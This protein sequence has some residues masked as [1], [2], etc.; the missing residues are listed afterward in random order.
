M[1]V[2]EKNIWRLVFE[3]PNFKRPHLCHTKKQIYVFNT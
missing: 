2:Y 3:T 1:A